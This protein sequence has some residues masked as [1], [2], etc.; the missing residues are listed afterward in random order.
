MGSLQLLIVVWENGQIMKDLGCVIGTFGN[1]NGEWASSSAA[2]N[3]PRT[4]SVF[5]A[6][7]V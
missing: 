4:A 6:G 1:Q 5:V 3:F 7:I 2:K